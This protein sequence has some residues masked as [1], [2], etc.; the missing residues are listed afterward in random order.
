MGVS[1]RE[2]GKALGISHTAVNKAALR[3]RIPREADGT[4]DLEKV[5]ASWDENANQ[6]QRQRRMGSVSASFAQG[7]HPDFEPT[8]PV[9]I[10][11]AKITMAEA[12][13]REAVAKA[14]QRELD[15]MEREGKLLAAEDVERE[16]SSIVS[17]ARNRLLLMAAKLAPRIAMVSDVRE[18]QALI[19]KEV[20]EALQK[21][22]E[23]RTD[24]A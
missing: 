4:F 14:K 13:R 10:D 12:Q 15:L 1:S 17:A 20:R 3:G 21:L 6:L 2:I 9:E 7:L 22:S 19:E 11:E 23:P 24:A 5:R 16:W 8:A 18:C